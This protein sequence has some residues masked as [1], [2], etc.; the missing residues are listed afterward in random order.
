MAL[1]GFALVAAGVLTR[2]IVNRLLRLGLVTLVILKLYFS[3][4]PGGSAAGHVLPHSRHR[5]RIEGWWTHD[6]TPR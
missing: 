1:Y 6:P 4:G 5:D 2:F 3:D